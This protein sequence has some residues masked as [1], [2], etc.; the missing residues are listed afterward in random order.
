MTP[1]RL[2]E[3]ERRVATYTKWA[4]D[5]RNA[6]QLSRLQ[7]DLFDEVLATARLAVTA[8]QEIRSAKQILDPGNDCFDSL[9]EVVAA[10]VTHRDELVAKLRAQRASPSSDSGPAPT[11]EAECEWCRAGNHVDSYRMHT[12]QTP[13]KAPRT[14]AGRVDA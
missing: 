12:V 13:C 3:I 4:Q 10:T 9:E 5:N 7:V 11:S 1:E 14:P 6:E 8:L 2:A